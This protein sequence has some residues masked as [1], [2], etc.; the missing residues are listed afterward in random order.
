ME[1]KN[2]TIKSTMLG[3]YEDHGIL[4]ALY[5]DYGDSSV[6][7]FGGYGL[8]EYSEEEK[9]RVPHIECGRWVKEILAY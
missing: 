5:L 7:G 3:Y 4:T 1:T 8:D 2:A 9:K 6:Q